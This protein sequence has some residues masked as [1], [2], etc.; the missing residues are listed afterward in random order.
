VEGDS[1]ELPEIQCSYDTDGKTP[2][3]ME[4]WKVLE[5]GAVKSRLMQDLDLE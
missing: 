2:P 5:V 3:G 1:G 4:V